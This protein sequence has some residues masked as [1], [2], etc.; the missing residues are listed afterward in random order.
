[1]WDVETLGAYLKGKREALNISLQEVAQVTRIRRS[2]LEAIENNRYD[3]LPPKVFA[4]GFVKSYASYLGLDESEVV[5]RYAELVEVP[6]AEV[7]T[8]EARMA[9]AAPRF[10]SIMWLFV[11][12][13]LI[14]AAA[15]LWRMNAPD[16]N[17]GDII[18]PPPPQADLTTTSIISMTTV[19]GEPV[20]AE[21]GREPASAPPVFGATGSPATAIVERQ[22]PAAG[23]PQA[24]TPEQPLTATV[25]SSPDAATP[26]K[27]PAAAAAAP[28]V[29]KI[30]ASQ[31]TWMRIQSD[32][33]RPVEFTLKGGQTRSVNA[34]EK[35]IIRI[36]NAGG[37]DLFLNDQE[38]GKPGKPGE[39]L[40]LTL[41][42]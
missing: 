1:M 29:L 10:S 41:P 32:T 21:S 26:E 35:F 4:Q 8:A 20:A 37:V 24:S 39:V 23:A 36:G 25:V 12:I 42:E 3:L 9:S 5:N 19:P 17:A 14:L 15:L 11:L 22:P 33:Q 2:I 13:A 16:K 27:P 30:V 38:L 34:M 18:S 7:K 28:L 6:E 31:N 40:Q